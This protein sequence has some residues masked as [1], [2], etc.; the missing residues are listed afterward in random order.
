MPSHARPKAVIRRRPSRPEQAGEISTRQRWVPMTLLAGS[1]TTPEAN[2]LKSAF[3][4]RKVIALVEAHKNLLPL[5]ARRKKR[6]AAAAQSHQRPLL[7]AI[8]HQKTGGIKA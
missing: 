3:D 7:R 1:T 8:C 6:S 2:R 5:S 4:R